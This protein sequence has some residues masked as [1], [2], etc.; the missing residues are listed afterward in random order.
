MVL[1]LGGKVR[2]YGEMFQIEGS[3]RE[4]GPVQAVSG[5]EAEGR[6]LLTVYKRST[7]G[8]QARADEGFMGGYR[9]MGG[10][11]VEKTWT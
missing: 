11:N 10:L 4:K 3:F 5:S 2:V 6:G 9:E 8:E 1:N 7:P